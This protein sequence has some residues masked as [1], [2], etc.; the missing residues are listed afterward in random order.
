MK[1]IQCVIAE[2]FLSRYPATVATSPYSPLASKLAAKCQLMYPAES[3]GVYR[4]TSDD[5]IAVARYRGLPVKML[6]NGDAQIGVSAEHFN[7]HKKNVAYDEAVICRCGF[8]PISFF[9]KDQ[10]TE[11]VMRSC[12]Q[13]C[14]DREVPDK[15]EIEQ[16]KERLLV[17]HKKAPTKLD[18]MNARVRG[19]ND[20]VPGGGAMI[21]AARE[22]DYKV[23]V[24]L[25][26]NFHITIKNAGRKL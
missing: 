19:E 21:F 5:I 8:S 4:I 13:K 6:S 22:L 11:T 12:C 26:G 10:P 25:E 9:L 17:Q 14:G 3:G 7:N 20:V 23:S 1:T 15:L 18:L 2:H 16:A 24:N